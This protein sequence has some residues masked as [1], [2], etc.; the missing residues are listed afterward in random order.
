MKK[1][2]IE[3]FTEFQC[4]HHLPNAQVIM[5]AHLGNHAVILI[6]RGPLIKSMDAYLQSIVVL[7]QIIHNYSEALVLQDT[8]VTFQDQ[9][10]HYLVPMNH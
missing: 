5:I 3:T 4:V 8:N 1:M 2:K 7:P 9:H 6:R 10:F